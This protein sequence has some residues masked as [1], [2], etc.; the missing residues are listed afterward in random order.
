MVSTLPERLCEPWSEVTGVV[1]RVDVVPRDAVVCVDKTVSSAEE[2]DADD[3]SN[4]SVDVL[5]SGE[6]STCGIRE[7]SL[8]RDVLE[9]TGDLDSDLDSSADE[10][11][12]KRAWASAFGS[13]IMA[14]EVRDVRGE[15]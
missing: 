3:E 6:S 15:P 4:D 10:G 11:R 2:D 7:S 8:S 1:S 5:D 9:R 14:A 13:M 12:G